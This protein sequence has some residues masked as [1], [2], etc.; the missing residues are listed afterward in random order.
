M[1]DAQGLGAAQIQGTGAP[2]GG[3]P[4]T[5]PPV[6]IPTP[7]GSRTP[8]EPPELV[9]PPGL[10]PIPVRHRW[11]RFEAPAGDA[12]WQPSATG[13]AEYGHL[14]IVI[15]GVDFTYLNGVPT[16]EPDTRE[17]EPFSYG[18]ATIRLPQIKVHDD[19]PPQAAAGANFAVR[20]KRLSDGGYDTVYE[21]IVG[22]TNDL[23]D[24]GPFTL[25]CDG[26]LMAANHQNTSPSFDTD[27][28]DIGAAIPD[29]INAATSVRYE[30]MD[31]TVT[32]ITTSVAGRWEPLLTGFVQARLAT[33]VK[34][35]KQY[36]LML[37]GRKPVLRA[38]DL[39]TIAW[40]VR[41]G[42][43][44]IKVD[45]TKDSTEAPNYI[46]GYGVNPAGGAWFNTLYPDA[47]YDD[48]PE[49]CFNDAGRS[50][51][52]GT[53]DA[54]TDTG[55]GVTLAQRKL[56]RPETGRWSWGDAEAAERFQEDHGLL[57]DG[58]VGPQTWAALFDIGANVGILTP[59]HAPLA[60]ATEVMP[61]LHGADGEDLGPNP[62]YDPNVPRI[63]RIIEYGQGVWRSEARRDAREVLARDSN[64]GYTGT[65]TFSIDPEQMPRHLIRAGQ[66]GLVRGHHDED[67]VVHVVDVKRRGG[68]VTAT[69]DSKARDLPTLQAIMQRDKAAMDPARSA[70]K[71]ITEA[72]VAT[73]RPTFDAESK[74]GRI[75]EHAIRED[76][77]DV[78]RIPMSKVGMAVLFEMQTFGPATE[79]STAAF[80][81]PIT[82]AQ[83]QAIVG[84]P[85]NVGADPLESPWD[86]H[87]KELREKFWFIDAWGWQEQPA[88]LGERARTTPNGTTSAPVTGELIH[89]G[90]WQYTTERSPW[91]YVATISRTSCFVKGRIY[92]APA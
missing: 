43:R 51:V 54:D 55:N 74:A 53:T 68:T 34:E 37:D 91:L 62:A 38:K 60:A 84:N 26:L 23:Q 24:S 27:P 1:A 7:G 4:Y 63:D 46:T 57:V 15:E 48:S 35:G 83:L 14:Q 90:S 56:D 16:P 3:K 66:N 28:K 22:G 8:P 11:E 77:F 71:R 69:V 86:V 10:E 5:L 61:R 82:A 58:V 2:V 73:D 64:P 67:I 80:G 75:P 72:A 78:R 6:T 13:A 45:L 89:R 79:F 40:E 31:R 20:V 59:F 81:K 88:G 21:G 39:T 92:G 9:I 41:A 65:I 32:G 30:P 25:Y 12:P 85:L 52:V 29:K 47:K 49:Y 70:V 17:S 87:A 50:V 76:L 19:I 33:A 18:P 36:T 44:L 42:Q